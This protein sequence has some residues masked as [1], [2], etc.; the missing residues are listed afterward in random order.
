MRAVFSRAAA[1]DLHELRRYLSPLSPAGLA[2]VTGAIE[3]RILATLEQPSS[4]RPSPQPGI[5]EAVEPRYGFVIPYAVRGENLI[6]LRIYRSSR[7]P[8]DYEALAKTMP[9]EE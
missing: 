9:R 4:G 6:V 3:R 5:R 1:R 2:S 7:K 8:L